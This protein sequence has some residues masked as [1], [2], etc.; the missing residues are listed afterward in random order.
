MNSLSVV[1]AARNDTHYR[2]LLRCLYSLRGVGYERVVVDM[3]A[4]DDSASLSELALT[5]GTRVMTP[6]PRVPEEYR[7]KNY[8]VRKAG[9]EWVL[10]TNA[11][12]VMPDEMVER[13]RDLQPM[14]D[15]FYRANRHDLDYTQKVVA[16]HTN[17]THAEGLHTNAAGDF[18][19]MHRDWWHKLRG[20]PE[21]AGWHQDAVLV[22]Q[23]AAAGMQQVILEEPIYHLPHPPFRQW[24]EAKLL[25]RNEEDWGSAK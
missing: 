18:L 2:N 23:A 9:G 10:V 21:Y 19:L 22:I 8:G 25:W 24:D 17:T 14:K 6:L 7:A 20:F 13:L 11:D 1:L 4:Q 15:S 16:V 3:G 5:A 12:I